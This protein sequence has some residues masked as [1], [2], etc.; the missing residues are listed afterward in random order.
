VR[1]S[2]MTVEHSARWSGSWRRCGNGETR[3]RTGSATTSATGKLATCDVGRQLAAGREQHGEAEAEALKKAAVTHA[4]SDHWAAPDRGPRWPLTRVHARGS[5]ARQRH[6][7]RWPRGF[8]A[9]IGKPQ[10]KKRSL[11]SGPLQNSFP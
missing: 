10:R 8:S 11:T 9:L 4:A 3:E 6:G 2:S 1:G 7:A 5:C